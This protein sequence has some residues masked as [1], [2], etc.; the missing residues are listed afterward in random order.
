MG[1]FYKGVR[2]IVGYAVKH[3]YSLWGMGGVSSISA[4]FE[5]GSVCVCDSI[6]P[7]PR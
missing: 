1:Y 5:K 6:N 2:G 3:L 7:N 4:A